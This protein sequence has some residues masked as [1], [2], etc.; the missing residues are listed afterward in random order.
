MTTA[1]IS[2]DKIS[3]LAE[4]YAAALYALAEEAKSLESVTDELNAL[5]RLIG[6]SAPLRRLI[7]SRAVA[8]A[9][10]SAAMSKILESQGFSDLVR[11]FVLTIVANRRIGD[12]PELI[13]GFIA[14]MAERRGIVTADVTS[15]HALSETQRIQLTAR[16]AEAGY[17]R[18]QINERVDPTLLGGL[19]V[20][21]GARLYDTSLKSRLQRLRHVMKGAA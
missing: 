9:D 13:S 3:T 7:N 6:E 12:L 18:V 1:A 5:R 2:T 19:V 15:A 14:Y 4:R 20:K 11:R 10:A 17:G 21:I 8:L 16:L